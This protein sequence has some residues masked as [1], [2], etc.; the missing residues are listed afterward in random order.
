MTALAQAGREFWRGVLATGGFT[1]VPRWTA[2]PEPGV[3]EYEV[4]VDAELVSALLRLAGDLGVRLESVLLAGHAK[5]LA[6]L[7]GEAE[8]VTGYLAGGQAFPCRL[9]TEPASWR[10]G[11]VYAAPGGAGP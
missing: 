9:T 2:N 7:S 11:G 8:V 1:A 4:P 10:G 6:A 5:V 3:A